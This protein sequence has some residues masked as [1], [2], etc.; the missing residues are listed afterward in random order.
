MS[1]AIEQIDF[2]ALAAWMDTCDLGSGPVQDVQL[3]AGGSQNILIRFRRS[4]RDYVLRH[5]PA[6][7]R[8]ESNETMRREARALSALAGTGV[9]H[10]ALIA[11]C[12]DET[13]LGAVFYLM[14]PVEGF[15]PAAGLPDLHAGSAA[16]RHRMGLSMIEALVALAKVDYRAVGLEGFGKPE[17]FLERQVGRWKKQLAGY[18]Q[19][20]GWPGAQALGGLAEVADWLERNRPASFKPGILHGDYHLANVMFCPDSGEVAA[21]V[22]WELATVGD[23]LVDLGWILATW[24]EDGE[25]PVMNIRPWDGFPTQSELVRHYREC[26]DHADFDAGWYA[27]FGCYKLAILL[28]GTFARACAGKASPEIGDKLH[29]RAKWLIGRASRWIADGMPFERGAGGLG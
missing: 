11:A 25:E 21:I 22:D 18:A 12:D 15:N 20:A 24:P 10:P 9:P 23:P 29:A 8:P 13:V 17:A 28:E 6:H 19:L 3:L 2:H 7:P 4:G 5:P 16:I 27:V 1:G 26:A 14:E